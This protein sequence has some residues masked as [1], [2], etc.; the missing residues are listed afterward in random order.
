ME[1][2]KRRYCTGDWIVHNR[3]GIGKVTGIVEK[4]LDGHIEEYF[5]IETSD[6]MYWLPVE[7]TYVDHIRPVSSEKEIRQALSIIRKIPE[8][9]ESKIQDRIRSI[10]DILSEGDLINL[11]CLMRDLNGRQ[12]I[13][14]LNFSESE[15]YSRLKKQFI[16]EWVASAGIDENEAEENLEKALFQSIKKLPEETSQV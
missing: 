7:N 1:V 11:A 8:T 15:I 13:K 9:L 6:S 2:E 14:R 16:E 10:S 3:Y 12:S 5:K 4:N